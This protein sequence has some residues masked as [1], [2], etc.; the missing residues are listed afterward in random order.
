[1]KASAFADE[2]ESCVCS[3]LE[4][5]SLYGDRPSVGQRLPAAIERGLLFDRH[6]CRDLT[7]PRAL[8]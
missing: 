1:M 8:S 2:R 5:L 3:A 4:M 6:R 7:G